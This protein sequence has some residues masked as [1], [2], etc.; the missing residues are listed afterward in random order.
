METIRKAVIEDVEAIVKIHEQAFPDF[1]LT[2]LGAKFLNLYYRCLC[3]SKNAVTLCAEENGMLVGFAMCSYVSHGFNTLL[4][5]RNL[6]KF[7]QMAIYLL[8]TNPKAVLRL[9]K[10]LDKKSNESIVDDKGEYAELYSIAVLPNHQ[11][12]GIG[13]SLLMAIEKDVIKHNGTIS[14]TTDYYDNDKTIGFY[15]SLGYKDFYEFVTYP[16]RRMWRMIKS[17]DLKK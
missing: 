12:M 2:T 14:L 13:K 5:K 8:F 6:Y 9:V 1:F 11:G 15:H 16:E 10:N 3:K 17:L 7:G 4:I